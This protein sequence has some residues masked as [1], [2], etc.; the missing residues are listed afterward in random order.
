[1]GRNDRGSRGS[2]H[3]EEDPLQQHSAKAW[4]FPKSVT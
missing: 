3:P 2:S 4:G 1:M